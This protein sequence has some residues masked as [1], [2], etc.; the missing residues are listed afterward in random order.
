MKTL[1][2]W[3]DPISPYAY[4]AFEHLPQALEDR[5]GGWRSSETSKAFGEYAGHVAARLSD[6]VRS[7]F[8]INEAGRFVDFGY[9]LGI[10]APGLKLPQ[11]EVNQ[12]RHHVALAHGLAVQAIRARGRAG[13]AD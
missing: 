9:G 8:T 10:D 5:I 13:T 1:T 2:F 11:R 6:R 4:L 12:V 3:F 7:I